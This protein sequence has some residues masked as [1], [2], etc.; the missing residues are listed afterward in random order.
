VV[1]PWNRT[2][3][4]RPDHCAER[5]VW[6]RELFERRIQYFRLIPV[7]RAGLSRELASHMRVGF[8]EYQARKRPRVVS[9]VETRTCSDL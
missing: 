9:N 1:E 4:Q 6:Q 7:L 3:N 5:V 2:Q 8:G